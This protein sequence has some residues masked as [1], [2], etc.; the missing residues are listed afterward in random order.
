[1]HIAIDGPT[2]SGKST[3]ARMLAAHFGWYYL[4]TGLLYRAIGYL[5]GEHPTEQVLHDCLAQL[6]YV[7]EHNEAK[8]IFRGQD[9]TSHLKTKEV[10]RIASIVAQDPMVR[11]ELLVFTRKLAQGKSLVMEGRDIGSVVL[12]DA[13]VKFFVT[14]SL[15]ERARR[16]QQY[17]KERGK[18]YSLEDALA[19]V[20]DRDLRDQ[21]RPHSPL[22]IPAG[23]HI[24]DNS[25]LNKE[26]TL[27]RMVEIINAHRNVSKF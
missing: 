1:M 16:W 26:E 12:P 13:E 8:V 9:I 20:Q 4:S 10:D 17:Q 2:A 14:A 3:V 6:S 22:V 23:A 25:H 15:E 7:Y 18:E 21:N 24:I 19:A 11:H 27:R 5:L